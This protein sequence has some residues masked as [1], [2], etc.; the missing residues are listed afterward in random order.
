[1]WALW[2]RYGLLIWP[3]YYRCAR[4]ESAASRQLSF[5]S[6]GYWIQRT[7]SSKRRIFRQAHFWAFFSLQQLSMMCFQ[8]FFPVC[9]WAWCVLYDGK[10]L[11]FFFTAL[12]LDVSVFFDLLLSLLLFWSVPDLQCHRRCYLFIFLAVFLHF[13]CTFQC[14]VYPTMTWKN[15][16]YNGIQSVWPWKFFVLFY[17]R[18]IFVRRVSSW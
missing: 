18:Q 14:T 10:Y 7:I 15:G 13:Q 5:R 3:Y 4:S 17:V 16:H 12:S 8:V 11:L 6:S 1:M 9:V 2:E